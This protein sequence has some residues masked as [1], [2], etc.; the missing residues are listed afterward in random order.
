MD[1]YFQFPI[2]HRCL[3]SA[4]MG[5]FSNKDI[6]EEPVINVQFSAPNQG[7]LILSIQTKRKSD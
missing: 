1:Y 3:V 6:V 5:E 7:I 2:S 4:T